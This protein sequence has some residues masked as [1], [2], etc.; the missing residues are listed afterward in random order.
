MVLHTARRLWFATR[1]EHDEMASPVTLQPAYMLHHRPYR[2]SSLLLEAF[3]R[4]YGRVGLVARAARRPRSPWR[5]TLQ[6][7]RSLLLSWTGRGELMTLTDAELAESGPFLSG[8]ALLSGFYMNE[9]VMR[10]LQRNDPHPA[11]FEAYGSALKGLAAAGGEEG[12]LRVFEKRLLDSA[13]YALVL[14][15]EPDT[16][17]AVVAG[18]RYRYLTEH[19]PVF[20]ERGPGGGVAVDGETLLSLARE[21]LTTPVVLREAK[22]LMRYVL[23]AHLG[24]R[25]LHSRELFQ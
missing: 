1:A 9:L 4:D 17:R 14:E 13:G 12:V 7:F 3:S 2:E 22:Q 15:S 16:G 21:E 19:G 8:R 20:G 5:G 6:P 18:A 23:R 10:L 24:G 11:L 25:P